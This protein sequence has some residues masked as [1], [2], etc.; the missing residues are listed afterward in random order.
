MRDERE[1]WLP[2]PGFPGYEVS[3][4]G[5]VRSY[6][7]SSSKT[8]SSEP[9]LLR[10]KISNHGYPVVTLFQDRRRT[11]WSVHALVAL[12]FV[13]PRPSGMDINHIDANKL[14]A[15]VENLEYV[16]RG[17]NI[18][19]A[20]ALGLMPVGRR[21]WNCKIGPENAAVIK[22]E[23][24][25]GVPQ[26]ALAR[27]FG[28]SQGA[29]QNI[30]RGI[31]WR[32]VAAAAAAVLVLSSPAAADWYT[33]STPTPLK[34]DAKPLPAGANSSKFIRAEDWNNFVKSPTEQLRTKVK[35]IQAEIDAE[36]VARAA[37]DTSETAARVA[38]DAGE[39]TAR[40]LED[41]SIRAQVAS[42]VL[43]GGVNIADT[44]TVLAE[45]ATTSRTLKAHL[46]EV[47]YVTGFGA[48]GD[49]VADDT[50]EWQNAIDVASAA[51]GKTVVASP[52]KTYL[53]GTLVP[54]A[55][56]TIDL[57]G[58]TLKR[59]TGTN[60]WLVFDNGRDATATPA[61]ER[62]G[63]RN[64]TLDGNIAGN[65]AGWSDGGITMSSWSFVEFRDLKAVGFF[66]AVFNL[67]AISNGIF[68]NIEVANCGQANGGGFYSYGLQFDA[69]STT[70][71][72]RI[73]V[74]NFTVRDTYGFGM[75][76]R[77]SEAFSAEN[78]SFTNLVRQ[79]DAIGLTLTEAKKGRVSNVIMSA[80][81]GDSFEVNASRDVLIQNMEVVNTGDIALLFGDNFTGIFNERVTIENFKASG[82][83][84]AFAARI[85]M[86]KGCTF[87]RLE[88]DKT[89]D[90]TVSGA[91]G[92]DVGNV[93]EDSTIAATLPVALTRYRKF[94]LSRVS[95]ANAF[96]ASLEGGR[97]VFTSPLNSSRSFGYTQ[98]TATSS[99]IEL[100]DLLGSSDLGYVGSAAGNLRTFAVSA[101]NPATQGAYQEAAFVIS[102]SGTDM[103]LGAVASLS[104]ATPRE[105]GITADAANKRIAL[106]NTTGLQ[107]AVR[108]QLE[109]TGF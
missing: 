105:L 75:H 98:D 106:A 39:T 46:A 57:R 99:Y 49:G 2:V 31:A 63:I 19:H 88:L 40:A 43:G 38:A 55:G 77:R 94:S 20:A 4:A 66:G 95:T 97:A 13:G 6:F 36:E 54:K 29:I 3:D 108:W 96:V 7:R 50:A 17:A 12:T 27:R 24:A 21:N 91:S 80:I 85:N 86:M 65:A 104:L 1:V 33:E 53:V 78:L 102:N 107:L 81:D 45:G 5:R 15:R 73:T 26:M 70:A 18:R 35:G 89:V 72:R 101:N 34:A 60:N 71:S 14:N 30:I 58:S 93:M 82:T 109:V 42:A 28:V 68:E 44:S 32:Y 79:A 83:G 48:V 103:T 52:G 67:A 74:R 64:G 8:L 92:N 69:N 76:F 100:D 41:A 56:V 62:F 37:A 87:R 16:T 90:T 51:G 61:L 11:Y 47:L 10:P 59:K 84:G 23:L 22:R 25:N 9:R